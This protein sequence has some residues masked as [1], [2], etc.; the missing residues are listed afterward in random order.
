MPHIVNVETEVLYRPDPKCRWGPCTDTLLLTGLAKNFAKT[1]GGC[2]TV[3]TN[4][5]N[6][7]LLFQVTDLPVFLSDLAER[8]Q[9]STIRWAPGSLGVKSTVGI[10]YVVNSVM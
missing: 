10:R 7:S 9:M 8:N 1:G 4:R 3:S 2:K 6:H 5:N